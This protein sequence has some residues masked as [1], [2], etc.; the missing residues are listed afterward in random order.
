MST[1]SPNMNVMIQAAEKAA[2]SLIRDF[3]EVEKLQVSRKG[4]GDFVSKADLRA[5][6]IIQYHLSEARPN[7]G[8]LMEEGGEV[9]GDVEHR[10]IIDPLDGTKNFLH[11]IPHWNTTIALEKGGEIIAGVVL[12]PIKDEMFWSEKGKGA[13]MNRSRLRVSGRT[14][15]EHSLIA[16]GSIKK[17]ENRFSLFENA[18]TIGIRRTA[19]CALDMS[20][21]AAGRYEGFYGQKEKAWDFAAASLIVQEAGGTVSTLDL[22]KN[23][24]ENNSGIICG[25][26]AIYQKMVKL[27][28]L[29][30]PS[31]QSA[32][33]SA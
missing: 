13:F 17:D 18:E 25:N 6:E 28:D 2:R 24:I 5:E 14:K 22:R 21:V 9:K 10:W 27:F 15:F 7:F 29:K 33:K 30:P 20:Y 8:F 32:Q 26:P 16:F 1:Y 12:D 11:G 31:K 4:P 23:Y 19:S 3:N